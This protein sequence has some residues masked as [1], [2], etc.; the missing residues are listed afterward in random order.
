VNSFGFS[1]VRLASAFIL[2]RNLPNGRKY[3]R[4]YQ[5]KYK[6][7]KD[8]KHRSV[9]LLTV[10]LILEDNL[11]KPAQQVEAEEEAPGKLA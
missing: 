10:S 3:R 8:K 7:I 6:I 9:D 4:R 2:N 5:G 1:P 11:S